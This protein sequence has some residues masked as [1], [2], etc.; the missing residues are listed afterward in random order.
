M[1]YG[2]NL[3]EL[4]NKKLDWRDSRPQIALTKSFN[5]HL[6]QAEGNFPARFFVCFG[7]KR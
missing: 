5:K 6:R 1:P 2:E 3:I 4:S 7:L